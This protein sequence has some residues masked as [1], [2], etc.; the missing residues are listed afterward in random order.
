M[1][2][3]FFHLFLKGAGMLRTRR[4]RGFTLIE[5]LVV[6]AIIAILIAML[7]PAVQK[8]R[9]TARRTQCANNLKQIGIA[10]HTYHDS[11]GV[12]PPG[13][14]IRI[15]TQLEGL[16]P[17]QTAMGDPIEC[18]SWS[19]AA[20]ALPHL[21]Q[22][23]LYDALLLPDSTLDEAHFYR[24]Q[25]LTS[26]LP[27][28]LC[29]SDIAQ[30]PLNKKRCLKTALGREVCVVAAGEAKSNYVASAPLAN[31]P[32]GVGPGGFWNRGIFTGNSS[33]S[34]EDITDGTSHTIL[35]GERRTGG[36]GDASIWPGANFGMDGD[37]GATRETNYGSA[38]FRMQTG[39]PVL[40]SHCAADTDNSDSD[41][42]DKPRWAFSSEHVGNGANFLMTDGSVRF[43]SENIQSAIMLSDYEQVEMWGIY[44][45]LQIRNDGVPIDSF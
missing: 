12:F 10:L 37:I 9:E 27:P 18:A 7:L 45:K 30:D 43:I 8:A 22:N 34:L 29:P 1:K 28:F 4:K 5:L 21:E 44:Q 16:N 41:C 33:T 24:Y 19:W 32:D 20:M 17:R 15:P 14:I 6:I 11:H 42:G 2:A 26:K 3:H 35:A 31:R 40:E 38:F 23:N 39:R 36:G 13:N 25:L